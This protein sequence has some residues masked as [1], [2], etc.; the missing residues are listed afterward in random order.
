MERGGSEGQWPFKISH[1]TPALVSA[2]DAIFPLPRATLSDPGAFS[3]SQA[4]ATALFCALKALFLFL[5]FIMESISPS[6][7]DSRQGQC[8]SC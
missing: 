1:L 8:P 4:G 5:S 6:V 2:G 7:L 3:P